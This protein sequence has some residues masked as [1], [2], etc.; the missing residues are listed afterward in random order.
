MVRKRWAARAVV[1]AEFK[2]PLLSTNARSFAITSALVAIANR[3]LQI[4]GPSPRPSPGVPGEGERGTS[5]HRQHHLKHSALSCKLHGLDSLLELHPPMDERDH[6]HLLLGQRANRFLEWSA[7]RA[8]DAH[9][10]DHHRRKIQRL[11]SGES[12]FE[13]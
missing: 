3:K 7:A 2:D 12:G 9:F 5:L 13:N 11:A 10:I 1:T 8:D 6:I 4:G